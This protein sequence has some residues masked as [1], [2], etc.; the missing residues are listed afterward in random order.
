MSN[1]KQIRGLHKICDKIGTMLKG[2]H[3]WIRGKAR[4]S[5]EDTDT[6]LRVELMSDKA[7]DDAKWNLSIYE[8]LIDEDQVKSG[9]RR[10]FQ[11]VRLKDSQ[12]LEFISLRMEIKKL[13]ARPI[14]VIQDSSIEEKGRLD[15][16]ASPF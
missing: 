8:V 12:E 2:D 9:N 15:A 13:S 3:L 16:P 11:L 1:A 6:L 4:S 5:R 14:R 7:T 10:D